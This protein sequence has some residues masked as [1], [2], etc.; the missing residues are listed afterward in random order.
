MDKSFVRSDEVMIVPVNSYQHVRWG[1]T[2]DLFARLINL[3]MR[4]VE[5]SGSAADIWQVKPDTNSGSLQALPFQI[6]P[7]MFVSAPHLIYTLDMNQDLYRVSS[8]GLS[9]ITVRYQL[10]YESVPGENFTT[11]SATWH[12]VVLNST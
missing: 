9:L 8:L 11:E 12:V 5:I 1:Q 2:V 6:L 7:H 3:T 10:A 4:D